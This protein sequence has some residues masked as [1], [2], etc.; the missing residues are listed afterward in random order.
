VIDPVQ[1]SAVRRFKG[2]DKA[3]NDRVD[4]APIAEALR[5]GQY[6]PTRLATDEVQSLRALTRYQQSLK[7]ELAEV[8][9]QRTCLLDSYSPE[10]SGALSDMFGAA[11]R[12]VLSKSPLPSRIARRRVGSLQRDISSAARGGRRMDGKAAELKALA[13]ASVG[14]RLGEDAAATQPVYEVQ[15]RVLKVFP[16][17]LCPRTHKTS[18][19]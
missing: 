9:T 17:P 2:L 14:I 6:D 3:K 7:A 4:A 5:I 19:S 13:K 16:A 11:G 10:F 15:E 18:R 1:A 8:K 12:A